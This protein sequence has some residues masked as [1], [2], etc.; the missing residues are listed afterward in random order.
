MKRT[1]VVI[2]LLGTASAVIWSTMRSDEVENASSNAVLT[3]TNR[4]FAGSRITAFHV[5]SDELLTG[6]TQGLMRIWSSDRTRVVQEW[7]AH[8]GPI[9]KNR[10]RVVFQ[11]SG[12]ELQHATSY[13]IGKQRPRS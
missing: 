13:S 5:Q 12:A 10:Q 4:A 2:A 7:F 11:S 3:T 9:R 1:M 6:D 8:D